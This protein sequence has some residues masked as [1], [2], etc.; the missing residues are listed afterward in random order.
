MSSLK[1]RYNL[2]IA[3]GVTALIAFVACAAIER[4]DPNAKA[5]PAFAC[6]DSGTTCYAPYSCNQ[7]G[8]CEYD[9]A[10]PVAT[11]WGGA[12]KENEAGALA[13][14]AG[15]TIGAMLSA[16]P[17]TVSIKN[18]SAEDK[19]VYI[20]FGA[21]SVALPANIPACEN[22]MSTRLTCQFPLTKGATS[23]LR[24]SSNYLNATISI[25][26][27]IACGST[28]A[29]VNVNN[30]RWYDTIDI[31]LV[32]GFSSPMSVETRDS[33]GAHV[34]GPVTGATNNEKAFGVFPYGC[35]ICVAR[36]S[37]P[38]GILPGGSGCKAGTQN[39]PS[40]I[41]QYK[42]PTLNGGSVVMIE[43]R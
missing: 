35:D 38:C 24:I 39:D 3:F 2:L 6:G 42:G 11:A 9:Q 33:A 21:D 28:K 17:S 30:P 22:E 27:P 36:K 25:G 13:T 8:K 23:G 20:S 34:L 32:D 10:G 14:D 19:T 41:C 26:A 16:T 40:V 31:S 5:D 18:G 15:T 37:P 7:Y 4:A 12:K 43:G 29:E 1:T